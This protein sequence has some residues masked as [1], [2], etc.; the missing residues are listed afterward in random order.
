MSMRRAATVPSERGIPRK[1]IA[2][3][4]MAIS[5]NADSTTA[6]DGTKVPMSLVARKDQEEAIREVVKQL[7]SRGWK[8]HL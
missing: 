6:A 7:E 1:F 8:E 5:A 2:A 4:V 3:A